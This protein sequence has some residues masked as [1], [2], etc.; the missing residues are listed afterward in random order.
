MKLLL[1][2]SLLFAGT[3]Q[4]GGTMSDYVVGSQDVLMVTVV[5]APELSNKYSVGNDGAFD[6]PWI[7]RIVAAGKTLRDLESLITKKLLDGGFLVRPQVTL[8]VD[9]FR[10]QKVY[11]MGEVRTPGSYSLTGATTIMDL[12]TQAGGMLQSAGDQILVNRRKGGGGT[13]DG[14]VLA[15]MESDVEVVK[16]PKIDVLSGRAARM[17]VLKDGDTIEV[18][19]G[20]AIFVTG[21]VKSPGRYVMEGQLTVLQAIALAGGP[22]ERASTK[23]TR[24]LRIVNGKEK[25]I[26]VKLNHFVQPG[27]TVAVPARI[28]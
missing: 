5:G 1:L 7:G 8:Q 2:V 6:F 23:R 26:K 4:R 12:I 9:Q 25:S 27:D 10:S 16:V 11:V 17:V 19:K 22:T 20:L 24:I 18:A 21:Y 3:G 14:P 15:G 28:F 13:D